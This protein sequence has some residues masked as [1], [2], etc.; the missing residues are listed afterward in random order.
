MTID[1]GQ[2]LS[3]IAVVT[4][5]LIGGVALAYAICLLCGDGPE[6]VDRDMGDTMP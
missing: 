2:I 1:I 4:A 6:D 3:S 5:L